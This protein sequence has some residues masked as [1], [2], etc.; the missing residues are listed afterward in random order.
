[1]NSMIFLFPHPRIGIFFFGLNV[2][3]ATQRVDISCKISIVYNRSEL[4]RMN[5]SPE[6]INI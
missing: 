2:D 5:R 3:I 4:I 1:M 6:T